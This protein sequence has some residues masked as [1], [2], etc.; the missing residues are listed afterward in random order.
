M[1]NESGEGPNSNVT[2]TVGTRLL[3]SVRKMAKADGRSVSGYIARVLAAH[4]AARE[5]AAHES[6]IRLAPAPE[7]E[8]PGWGGG[9]P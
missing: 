4:V 7:I 8:W 5:G 2:I 6:A 9:E 1:T 3:V